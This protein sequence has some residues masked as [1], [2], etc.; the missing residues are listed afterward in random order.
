MSRETF[1][2]K[3]ELFLKQY[4]LPD[5]KLLVAFSGGWDSM[6][7]LDLL[8]GIGADVTAIHLNHNWRGAQSLAEAQACGEFCKAR[9]VEFYA[10]TLDDSV[11]Q[12]ETA[13]REARY[14]FFERCA[15]KFGS[16]CV[17]TAHNYDDNAETLLYRITKGTGTRGLEGIKEKR[18]SS[19]SP[20]RGRVVT[21]YRPLLGVTRAEIEAY[22]RENNLQPNNDSSNTDTK[23][24]RNLIRAEIL[25]RLKEINPD[26]VKSLNSLSQVAAFD[27]QL[28]DEYLASLDEPFKNFHSF[29]PALKSRL[30]Y[31]IFTDNGV[32][33]DRTRINIILDFIE[34]NKHSKPAKTVSITTNLWLAAGTNGIEVLTRHPAHR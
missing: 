28:I 1:I 8:V 30:I 11:A 13:A 22:C 17:L 5:N 33:Y 29:T 26:V 20:A 31:K 2:K 19:P 34:E 23:Y 25:P 15:Q 21:Y 32:D 24:K 7:L 18:E 6:C 14:Q 27:N 16:T 9:G 4:S 12:T 3:I 10:E